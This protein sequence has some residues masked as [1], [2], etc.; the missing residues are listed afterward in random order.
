MTTKTWMAAGLLAL[1]AG[2]AAAE[3][4]PPIACN[5]KAL[6]AAQRKQLEET[7]RL[8]IAA[9]T[10]SRELPDGYAFRIEP[11]KATLMDVARWLDVW[12]RCCP[13]YEF[14]IDFHGA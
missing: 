10:G 3:T 11:A 5:M 1:G 8:V 7:G 9:I 2:S 4:L 13:F 14:E 6:N 12:R